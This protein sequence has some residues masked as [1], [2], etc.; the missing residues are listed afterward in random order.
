MKK[1]KHIIMMNGEAVYN[2]FHIPET[3]TGTEQERRKKQ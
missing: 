3:E 1:S 2:R